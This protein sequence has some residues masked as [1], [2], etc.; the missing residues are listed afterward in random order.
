[1]KI[2]LMTLPLVCAAAAVLAQ[3]V[4]QPGAARADTTLEQEQVQ[5]QVAPGREPVK[6]TQR[7]G[8]DMRHCLELKNSQ[9]IIRCAEPGR[10][11]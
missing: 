8:A 7:Q 4:A 5:A 11:P 6:D 1:M 10:K 3:D 9:D 2:L